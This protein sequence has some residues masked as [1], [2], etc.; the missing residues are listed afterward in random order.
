MSDQAG[1]GEPALQGRNALLTGDGLVADA[2]AAGLERAGA[3]V[4][5]ADG[6]G[7]LPSAID[8]LVN[9]LD[10]APAGA[11]ATIEGSAFDGTFDATMGRLYTLMQKA[12][13][14]MQARDGAIVNIVRIEAS[15]EDGLLAGLADG[16]DSLTACFAAAYGPS[17]PGIRANAIRTGMPET[18]A[19]VSAL[20]DI[21]IL[22]AS[23]QSSYMNG[24]VIPILSALRP[25]AV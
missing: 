17:S 8:V 25:T 4:R 20:I 13:P 6:T 18:P 14:A 19:D 24:A 7:A 5:R 9:W 15:P 23:R 3:T 2:I 21:V 12:V 1:T 11:L 10:P 22:L 16:M